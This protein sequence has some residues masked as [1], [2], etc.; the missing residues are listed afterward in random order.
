MISS[1]ANF[2]LVNTAVVLVG[3]SY[4]P[5]Q[6]SL[7]FLKSAGVAQQGWELAEQPL[8]TPV[9]SRIAFSNG[10]VFS[11][12]SQ[13]IQIIDNLPPEND[14]IAAIAIRFLNNLGYVRHTAV[15][16]NFGGILPIPD[17]ST[18]LS[19]RFLKSGPWS[20]D[21]QDLMMEFVFVIGTVRLKM[22]IGTGKAQLSKIGELT[23]VIAE[24][25]F[26]NDLSSAK[27]LDESIR[28]ANKAIERFPEWIS[29]Y[30]DTVTRFLS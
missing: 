26:H 8:S 12:E 1:L 19:E 6:L 9:M 3:Q 2:H 18:F 17:G 5:L 22:G 4:N 10:V 7:D 29:H 14:R 23:G 25:N 16:L 30:D 15:G 20:T 27:S 28:E 13:R 11:A 21:L 24:A